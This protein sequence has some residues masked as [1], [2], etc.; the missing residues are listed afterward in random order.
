MK[1]LFDP[2]KILEYAVIAVLRVVF[3]ADEL[4]FYILQQLKILNKF[5]SVSKYNFFCHIFMSEYIHFNA[6]IV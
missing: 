2:S 3:G 6:V 4:Q 5:W 1:H